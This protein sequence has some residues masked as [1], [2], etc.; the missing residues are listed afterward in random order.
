[1][2]LSKKENFQIYYFNLKADYNHHSPPQNRVQR[3]EKKN[4]R[5]NPSLREQSE[6]QNRRNPNPDSKNKTNRRKERE[7][8]QRENEGT[9]RRSLRL[10]S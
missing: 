4:H 8:E 5:R 6:H 10:W 1:M 9:R 2:D 7:A 3:P